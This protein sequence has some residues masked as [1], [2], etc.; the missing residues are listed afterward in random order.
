[1][2]TTKTETLRWIGEADGHLELIDQTL[3]PTEFTE[4][5]CK[6]VQTVWHAIKQLKV[7]GAPAIGIAAGYGMVVGLQTVSDSASQE[8]FF[9]RSEGGFR[10]PGGQPPYRSQSVLGN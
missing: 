7:R 4:I 1:M 9:S 3:L 6:D 2:N 10:L 5:A 8:E